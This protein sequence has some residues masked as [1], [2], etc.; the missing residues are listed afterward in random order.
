MGS[1]RVPIVGSVGSGWPAD[2]VG[3]VARW[4]L[5]LG[6]G[7][8]DGSPTVS[9]STSYVPVTPDPGVACTPTQTRDSTQIARSSHVARGNHDHTSVL[10]VLVR[11]LDGLR[12]VDS[13]GG[14]P[15]SATTAMPSVVVR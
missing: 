13:Q 14:Q 12:R 11:A 9:R 7:P 15:K 10:T 2:P 5:L 1:S 4:V 8:R 3:I 6:L